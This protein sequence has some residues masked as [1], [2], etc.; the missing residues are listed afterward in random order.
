MDA[1]TRPEYLLL[2]LEQGERSLKDHTRLFLAIANITSYPDDALC[3]FC[4]ASPEPTCRAPSSED[5]P[6]AYFAAF[7]EWILARNG[8]PLTICPV[9]DLGSST[10]DPEPSPPSP[11]CA[12]QKPEPT[13]DGEPEPAAT[14][15]PSHLG[16]TELRI[17]AEPE[18]RVTSDRVR[19]PATTPAM[20]EKA[21]ASEIAE[22]SSTHCTL[23]EGELLMD[24]GEWK[25]EGYLI[26][27]YADLPPLLPPLSE[28][29]CHSCPPSSPE[30]ALV[31]TSG[32]GRPQIPS[33]ARRAP[34][35]CPSRERSCP[36][37]QPR[38]GSRS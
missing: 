8:L 14:D 20:R 2:L 38:E 24:L 25:A 6:Q 4:D 23:A 21:M 7:V 30:R 35:F 31:P 17:A 37:V 32:P 13:D 9:E 28:A 11:S 5:G 26:Y 27:L 1:L 36:P 16:A 19:E 12:E 18:L 22:R 3:A 34:V 33:L 15:E 29:L 10:P